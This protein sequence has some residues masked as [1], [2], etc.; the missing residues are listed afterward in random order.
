M[1]PASVL[2]TL[3]VAV[4]LH[5][6][7]FDFASAPKG[8]GKGVEGGQGE[9]VEDAGLVASLDRLVHD[10]L[11][12]AVVFLECRESGLARGS[13]VDASHG[14]GKVSWLISLSR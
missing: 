10:F 8:E 2:A 9:V 11:M 3:S 14:W 5:R 1:K 12:R 13:K 7:G 4:L 6:L